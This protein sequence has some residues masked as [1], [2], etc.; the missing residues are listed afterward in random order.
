MSF[1]NFRMK[2]SSRVKI[3]YDQQIKSKFKN[4]V[5][6]FLRVI[7]TKIFKSQ[8]SVKFLSFRYWELSTGQFP[9]SN[10]EPQ[11]GDLK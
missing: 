9:H 10:T 4:M 8:V 6:N 2:H 3:K 7:V 11:Y 5:K 1:I